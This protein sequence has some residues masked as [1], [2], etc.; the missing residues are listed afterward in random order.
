VIT[1]LD[2]GQGTIFVV[3]IPLPVMASHNPIDS[4]VQ[5]AASETV[6]DAIDK[7][8]VSYQW[9]PFLISDLFIS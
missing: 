2:F 7:V 4:S 5:E 8:K 9:R 3:A 6:T 1:W